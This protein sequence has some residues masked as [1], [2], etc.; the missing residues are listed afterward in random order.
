MNENLKRGLIIGGSILGGL[1]FI[2]GIYAI[3]ISCP[4]PFDQGTVVAKRIEPYREYRTQTEEDVTRRE[5][6]I[7]EKGESD[8]RNVHDYTIYKE[9]LNKD[10]EDFIIVIQ[11]KRVANYLFWKSTLEYTTD[12]FVSKATFESLHEGGVFSVKEFGGSIHDE[13]NERLLLRTWNDDYGRIW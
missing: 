6:Y 9:W 12:Y 2:W 1:I 3:I 11:N 5:Y 8:W 13:N 10:F 7:N 4:L